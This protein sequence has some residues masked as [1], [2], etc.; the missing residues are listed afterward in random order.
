MKFVHVTDLH[1]VA[2]GAKPFGKDPAGRLKACLEDIANL[3]NDAEFCVITGDLTENGDI[4][5]Y[6]TLKAS[7]AG[8]SLRT[9]LLLG[10]CDNRQNFRKVFFGKAG[11][12]AVQAEARYGEDHHL[13]LDT[14]DEEGS[15]SGRYDESRRAWLAAKLGAS[16]N[17]SI[18]LHMHHPP[19]AIGHMNDVIGLKD[20]EQF[21]ALIEGYP[22]RH[23]FFGHMHRPVSGTW[24]RIG[25]SG[26]PGLPF[27]LRLVPQSGAESI[28][29]EPPMYGVVLVRPDAVIVHFDAFLHRL[30]LVADEGA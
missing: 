17:G 26:L 10:N 19:F 18:Y 30:P 21:A 5:A 6:E 25:F 15:A 12:G 7:L 23:I 8:F 4:E 16:A 14:L 13:F 27:Q 24:K 28:T 1:L 29:D 2:A 11:D 9:H 3:H 20:R 22:I